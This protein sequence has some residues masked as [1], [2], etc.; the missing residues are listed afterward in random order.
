[1]L[2]NVHVQ[3]YYSEK[4]STDGKI[5][6]KKCFRCHECNKMLSVGTYA[7]LEGQLFCKPCFKKCFKRNGNYANGFGKEQHK[8]KWATPKS[9]DV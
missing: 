3:V 9:I 6:H 7:A 2:P 5:F 8:M 4:V 1:M